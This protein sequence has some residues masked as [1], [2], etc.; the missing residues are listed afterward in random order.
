MANYWAQRTAILFP[1]IAGHDGPARTVSKDAYVDMH[2]DP[3]NPF[4]NSV[5]YVYYDETTYMKAK[6][7]KIIILAAENYLR[8]FNINK[9]SRFDIIIVISKGKTNR[10]EHIEDA[11]YPTLR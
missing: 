5:S 8:R 3:N 9:N 10:I 6:K 4:S 2:F 11:Y 7:H 1:R